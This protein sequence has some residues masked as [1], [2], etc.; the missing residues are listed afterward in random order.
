MNCSVAGIVVLRN[1]VKRVWE[2]VVWFIALFG[3]AGLII[4]AVLWN[5]LD[6]DRFLPPVYEP[7]FRAK[8]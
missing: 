1:F 2:R 8:A 4:F 5:V 3:C 6:T 7:Y